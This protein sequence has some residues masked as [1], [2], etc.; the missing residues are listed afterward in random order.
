MKQHNGLFRYIY[1]DGNRVSLKHTRRP[2]CLASP[3]RQV[4]V[5]LLGWLDAYLVPITISATQCLPYLLL[6]KLTKKGMK[7]SEL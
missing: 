1:Y 6:V 2:Y 4:S 5:K 7:F 3:H